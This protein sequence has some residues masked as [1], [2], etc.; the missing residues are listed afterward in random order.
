M[1]LGLLV[2][3]FGEFLSEPAPPAPKNPPAPVSFPADLTRLRDAFNHHIIP[4]AL[5]AR[6]DGEAV[7]PERLVILRYCQKRA[8]NADAALTLDEVA[9]L[10]DYLRD[11]KPTRGQLASAIKRLEHD[12]KADIAD[13]I[14]AA[15]GVVDADGERRPREVQFLAELSRDLAAL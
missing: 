9:A 7:M 14:A 8:K 15:Q 10:G 1:S 4:L 12:S 11:F 5:L 13:L 3:R 2:G 6:S